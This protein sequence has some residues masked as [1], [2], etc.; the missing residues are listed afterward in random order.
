MN[1]SFKKGNF[2]D[3]YYQ[4]LVE[5]SKFTESKP[6]ITPSYTSLSYM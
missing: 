2:M 6:S 3:T 1:P 5:S 4:S